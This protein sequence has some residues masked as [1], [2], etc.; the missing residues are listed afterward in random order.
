MDNSYY[1]IFSAFLSHE[2]YSEGFLATVRKFSSELNLDSVKSCLI[3]GPGDG[4]YEVLFLKQCVPNISK[5]IAVEP[6]HESVV[7]LRVR[8]EKSLPNVD[9]QVIET[10]IQSWK[11]LDAPVDLVLMMHVLYHVSPSERKELFKKLHEQW[12]VTEG[13]MVVASASRTKCPGSANDIFARLGTP[14]LA[15]EDFEPDMLEAGFIKRHAHEM[16]SIRDFSN[17]DESYLLL[18]Q[19]LIDHPV[20]LDDVRNAIKELF[21]DGKSDQVFNTLA[22]FQKA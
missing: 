19:H 20:T 18:Y 1:E 11:G 13:R 7:R 21:P 14:L 8:L 6:D 3:I 17:V 4:Q 16:Q 9:S 15:W 12:L 10:N 22:V 5:L 2:N